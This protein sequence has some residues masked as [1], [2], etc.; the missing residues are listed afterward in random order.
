MWFSWSPTTAI[1]GKSKPYDGLLTT[2]LFS[3][4]DIDADFGGKKL[5]FLTATS[6]ADPNQVAYWRH[7]VVAAIPMTM[8]NGRITR[9]GD[10]RW[11]CR[12]MP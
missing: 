12:S 9:A 4:Y 2:G 8:T 7:E 11:P 1:L 5:S 3:Q 6:C 10:D